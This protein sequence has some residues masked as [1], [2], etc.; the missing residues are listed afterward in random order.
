MAHDPASRFPTSGESR[1]AA[2][3]R[4]GLAW[5][6]VLMGI[7]ML[8]VESLAPAELIAGAVA[9]AAAAS[10]AELVRE[11]GYVRFAPRAGWLVHVP[12]VALQ[13]LRDCAILGAALGR[14]VLRRRPVRGVLIRVPIRYGDAGGRASARRAL[15]NFGV[16]ITPNSYVVHLDDETSTALIHQLVPGPLDPL[17]EGYDDAEAAPADRPEAQA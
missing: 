4:F 11:R 14:R 6:A 7:W 15:L 9:A 5:W 17:V 12:R 3:W 1:V 8:F 10:L 2:R 13:I 16:S